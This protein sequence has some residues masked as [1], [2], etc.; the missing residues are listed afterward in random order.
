VAK[1]LA[2]RITQ[3]GNLGVVQYKFH[4]ELDSEWRGAEAIDEVL[5]GVEILTSLP[6]G[7]P[8]IMPRFETPPYQ[9]A[10]TRRAVEQKA[11]RHVSDEHSKEWLL[12]LVRNGELCLEVT[13][14]F[15]EGEVGQTGVFKV[16]DKEWQ[17]RVISDRPSAEEFWNFRAA[18]KL[19]Q[20]QAHDAQ[21]AARAVDLLRKQYKLKAVLNRP[22]D[23]QLAARRSQRSKAKKSKRVAPPVVDSDGDDESD[24]EEITPV[25]GAGRGLMLIAVVMQSGVASHLAIAERI[26]LGGEDDSAWLYGQVPKQPKGVYGPGFIDTRDGLR[27][28]MLAGD[29]PK[30]WDPSGENGD[31][32]GRID[33]LNSPEEQHIEYQVVVDGFALTRG[34]RIPASVLR[35][36]RERV[37]SKFSLEEELAFT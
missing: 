2:W 17:V 32:K 22:T 8:D 29:F 26:D 12:G 15:E 28:N 9:S 21:D 4:G 30:N 19:E 35:A 11:L 23:A 5:E 33:N 10:A 1:P 16:G 25:K 31:W 20:R 37:V 3:D 24:G 18:G 36:T 13:P 14:G 6:K 27:Q 7:R 34:G